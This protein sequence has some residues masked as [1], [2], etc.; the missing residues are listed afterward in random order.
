MLVILA[1]IALSFIVL[2]TAFRSL[3]LSATQAAAA[4]S[5]SRWR[6]RSAFLTAALR[7]WGRARN[8]SVGLDIGER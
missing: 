6:R 5:P 2:L 8:L 4:N 3:W 1:V 7:R